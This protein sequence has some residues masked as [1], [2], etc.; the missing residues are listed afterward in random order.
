MHIKTF[1]HIGLPPITVRVEKSGMLFTTWPDESIL[2]ELKPAKLKNGQ[3]WRGHL[4]TKGWFTKKME[5]F[6]LKSLDD[7][8]DL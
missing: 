1:F 2:Y 3:S 4:K 7:E 6:I 5:E 8:S